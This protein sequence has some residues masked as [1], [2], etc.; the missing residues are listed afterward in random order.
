MKCTFSA[1]CC[2]VK[3]NVYEYV[4]LGWNLTVVVTIPFFINV[5]QVKIFNKHLEPISYQQTLKR[6]N[7]IVVVSV[8]LVVV[9]FWLSGLLMGFI[10]LCPALR[11]MLC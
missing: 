6:W 8:A 5:N 4:S 10:P 1:S 2:Y 9:V 11:Q 7:C 3:Q